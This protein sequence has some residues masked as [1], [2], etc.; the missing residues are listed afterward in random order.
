MLFCYVIKETIQLMFFSNQLNGL[1]D[2][3]QAAKHVS[4]PNYVKIDVL[5]YEVPYIN[6][7]A[8]FSRESISSIINAKS[9]SVLPIFSIF[10][11]ANDTEGGFRGFVMVCLSI[12][13]DCFHHLTTTTKN[14]FFDFNMKIKDC[15]AL[16]T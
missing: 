7:Y 6:S 1:Y 11:P 9:S 10:S 2:S 13:L 12:F 16:T 5:L 4:R 14:P 3:I 15:S 8:E